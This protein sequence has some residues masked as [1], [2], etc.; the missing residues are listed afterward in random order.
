MNRI[1][2][3][4]CVLLLA[5]CVAD[6]EVDEQETVASTEAAAPE[7]I[8][9]CDL[10]PGSAVED[11]MG[12][13]VQEARPEE[14]EDSFDRSPDPR[15]MTSCTY[16][17]PAGQAVRTATIQVARAPEVADPTASLQLYVE[18]L[19][20]FSPGVNLTPVP[21]LGPGAGWHS[22]VEQLSVFRP[23]WRIM[24]SVD[25]QGAIPG[26]EGATLLASRMLERMPGGQ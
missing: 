9:A 5:G 25:R 1:T 12:E 23:G 26:L 24:A 20:E 15:Y 6:Q 17:S 14:Y 18:G 8:V 7:R 2:R 4:A 10:L 11:V 16:I 22:E 21:E 13:P 19:R 3:A